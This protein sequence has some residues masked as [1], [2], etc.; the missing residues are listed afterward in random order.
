M[1][2]KTTRDVIAGRGEAK[3]TSALSSGGYRY[4]CFGDDGVRLSKP[5]WY[6]TPELGVPE[7]DVRELIRIVGQG[8]LYG[9][10]KRDDTPKGRQFM[11]FQS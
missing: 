2:A 10:D 4:E 8:P 1:T 9:Q 6:G 11:S 3:T 5:D 7:G